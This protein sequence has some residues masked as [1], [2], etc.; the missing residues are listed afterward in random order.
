MSIPCSFIGG[1]IQLDPSIYKPVLGVV[2]ALAALKLF[3]KPKQHQAR[4]A[5]LLV[6]LLLGATIGL[7]S[8]MIG[9]GGG[10]FLSPILLLCGFANA[11]ETAAISAPFILCNS[12]AAL[13]G[14]IANEPAMGGLTV[15]SLPLV[16][17]VIVGGIIGANI[18]SRT[19]GQGGLRMMLGVV[20]V[21]ASI[22]MFL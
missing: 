5:P 20:L 4:S 8:G 3:M 17:A 12:I 13:I 11:K 6:V 2:L 1:L 22:K 18:G 16:T 9:I 10:I 21:V 15:N 14:V 7:V 19:L